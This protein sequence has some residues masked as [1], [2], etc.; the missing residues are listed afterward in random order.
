MSWLAPVRELLAGWRLPALSPR[1]VAAGAAVVA[2]ATVAVWWARG[3]GR[4]PPGP[5]PWPLLGNLPQLSEKLHE[6]L[7]S[8]G[9]VY[10][11]VFTLYMATR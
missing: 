5:R 8:M 7:V 6:D 2:G 1:A 9:Q 10:G 11:E 3:R 4:L